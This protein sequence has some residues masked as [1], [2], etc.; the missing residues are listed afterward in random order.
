MK[1]I[2]LIGLI[3]I[4]IYGCTPATPCQECNT[5]NISE[6]GEQL[7]QAKQGMNYTHYNDTEHYIG[8]KHP[9]IPRLSGRVSNVYIYEE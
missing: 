5:F 2:I 3:C 4:L 8:C 1:A 9:L 7:C 6:I